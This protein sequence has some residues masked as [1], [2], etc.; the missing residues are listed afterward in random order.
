M[1]GTLW[2]VAEKII[3][4]Y[5]GHEQDC[6][7]DEEQDGEEERAKAADPMASPRV[8]PSSGHVF[9]LN[10]VYACRA[11]H[12]P[13][14]HL[15]WYLP[16]HDHARASVYASQRRRSVS[17]CKSSVVCIYFMAPRWSR[18]GQHQPDNGTPPP[19]TKS[20]RQTRWF[21]RSTSSDF[22]CG[23]SFDTR[24][25]LPVGNSRSIRHCSSHRA[26]TRLDRNMTR[27]S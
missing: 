7:R 6:D 3:T 5:A 9:P 21:S 20:P 1:R 11:L 26:H 17:A 15:S 27:N 19:K 13:R 12:L 8:S 4:A 10:P 23:R 14:P 25:S 22:N 24:K 18:I 16:V 2:V